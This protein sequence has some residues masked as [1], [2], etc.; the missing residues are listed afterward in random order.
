MSQIQS[1]FVQLDPDRETVVICHH[2]VRSFHVCIGRK[3]QFKRCL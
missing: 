3:C 2:G 1:T